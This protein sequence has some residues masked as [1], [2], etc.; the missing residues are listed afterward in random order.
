VEKP[1]TPEKEAGTPAATPRPT[2]DVSTA[3]KVRWRLQSAYAAN[4]PTAASSLSKQVSALSNG[5]MTVDVF[6]AGQLLPPFEIFDAVAK[7]V[8]EL[9]YAPGSYWV[10]KSKA[11]S[12][13]SGIPFGFAPRDH[14]RFRH[15]ADVSDAFEQLLAPRGL[16]ALP[17][18]SFGRTGEMWLKRAISTAD[19][20]RGLRVRVAGIDADIYRGLGAVPISL[21]SGEIYPALER[22]VIDG[23]RFLSPKVD[24]DLGF[25]QVTKFYYY[26]G[27]IPPAN[28]VDL[29]INRQRWTSLS[30]SG[31]AIITRACLDAAN[32]MLEQHER[33]DR[34]ALVEMARR[35]VTVS[36]VP[37]PLARSM[38]AAS[39]KVLGALAG[40]ATSWPVMSIV[41]QMRST[42]V[43]A[44]LP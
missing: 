14:L 31:R 9:G 30:E 29:L 34:E 24:L 28:V 37:V 35:G 21:P 8:V 5:R 25:N 20:L 15:R 4:Q 3:P 42:T 36:P 26:P 32:A 18:G 13:M 23:A 7:G 44:Q 17:C 11:F 1:A 38:L 16:V 27:L 41:E 33:A 19:D 40:E 43:A 2:I 6:P 39:R 12:L 22:G 10:W